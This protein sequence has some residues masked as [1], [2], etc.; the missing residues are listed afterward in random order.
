[1]LT[2]PHSFAS[3]KMVCTGD[4]VWSAKHTTQRLLTAFGVDFVL[5]MKHIRSHVTL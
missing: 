5:L 3:V 2:S 1:M 4:V